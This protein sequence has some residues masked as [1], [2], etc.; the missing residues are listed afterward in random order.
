M[1]TK[2]AELNALMECLFSGRTSAAAAAAHVL[3]S[4]RVAGEYAP[5]SWQKRR[6]EMRLAD[7]LS[8]DRSR[9]RG[10]EADF[11]AASG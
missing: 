3:T 1:N 10:A 8:I 2:I 7:D 9:N 6:V 11:C 5:A 4:S